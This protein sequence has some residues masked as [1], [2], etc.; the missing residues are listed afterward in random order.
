[1][2]SD[3]M[4]RRWADGEFDD[5]QHGIKTV[6]SK[7]GYYKSIYMRSQ[8]EIQCASVLDSFNIKWIYEPER[9]KLK[10]CTYLPDFYL[11]EFNIYLEVKGQDQG[12]EKVQAFRDSGKSVILVRKEDLL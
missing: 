6:R 10:D 11:P 4:K 9:F 7:P 12:L 2:L 5:K 8:L 3:R 1:M